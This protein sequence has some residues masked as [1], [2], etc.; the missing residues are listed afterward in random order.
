MQRHVALGV[1]MLGAVGGSMRRVL[2]I[3]LAHHERYDAASPTGPD[4]DG[5]P[6]AAR[7]VKL[8][9]VYDSLTS[10]RPYRKAMP[11]FEVKTIIVN[12][13]GSD[14]TW[15]WCDVHPRPSKPGRW[16]CQRGVKAPRSLVPASPSGA[17]SVRQP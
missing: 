10:D 13:S 11:P 5:I 3:V 7:V 17:R 6:L 4:A 15:S 12:G 8:A 2:P 16:S 14:S 9:D 1:E